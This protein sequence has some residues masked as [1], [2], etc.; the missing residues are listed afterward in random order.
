M[1]RFN[2]QLA[3]AFGNSFVVTDTHVRQSAGGTERHVVTHAEWQELEA[4]LDELL[5]NYT[6]NGAGRYDR[7]LT[8]TDATD[9]VVF[10]VTDDD[11]DVIVN[12]TGPG[13]NTS[14][15]TADWEELST[16]IQALIEATV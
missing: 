8:L 5:L 16:K 13:L 6:V 9:L 10:T 12:Q 4:E 7:S 2:N 3:D 14:Y 11:T 1:D 15:S